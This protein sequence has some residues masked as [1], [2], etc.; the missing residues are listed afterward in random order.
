LKII[1]GG[2]S[3][4]KRRNLRELLPL[5]YAVMLCANLSFIALAFSIDDPVTIFNG[6]INII[7]SRSVLITDYIAI[8]GLGAALINVAIAGISSLA[9]LIGS[10]IKPTGAVIMALWLTAGFAFFGKNVFNMIPLT[11]GVWLYS[12]YRKEPFSNY[13]LASLLVATLSPVVSEI[14]FLGVFSMPIE[15]LLGVLLGFV[16]GFIFPPISSHMVR[17]HSGYD[18]YS[19]G[20]AGGLIATIVATTAR[21]MGHVIVPATETSYGYNLPLSIMLYI[22]SVAMIII[23][24]VTGDEDSVGKNVKVS[25]KEYLKFHK[26]SG[27]LITDFFF[28]YKNSIYINMGVLC[29]IATTIVLVL[30]AQFEGIVMAAVFTI[31]GFACFGKHTL[32]IIPIMIGA[33]LSAYFNLWDMTGS[34]NI[35]AVLFA[36]ALAPIAGKFG[37][38]W[39]IVAGFLHVSVA[40]FV[41]EMNGGLNLYNN[42]F[43][44]GFIAMFLIPVITVSERM[45]KSHEE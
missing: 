42:G 23:G 26:H 8:G 40:M 13:T 1:S 37:W 36:S 15:I 2:F 3:M 11:V 28:L 25:F 17:A 20:F 5:P 35:A 33:G 31:V 29:A 45:R 24:L 44:A 27:R 43:A 7:T 30:G 22:F 10:K 41:G 19:M 21:S 34:A 39:G 16:I 9:M 6:F 4:E 32:N 38:I 12:K 18:L 14:S